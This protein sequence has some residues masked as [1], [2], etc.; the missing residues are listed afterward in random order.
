M[1]AG[2][3]PLA[4]LFALLI[5]AASAAAQ[6]TGPSDRVPRLL[7]VTATPIQSFNRDEPERVRF[8][9]LEFLGGLELEADDKRFGGISGIR[10][11][12]GDEGFLAI[13]DRAHWLRGRISVEG[14]RPVGIETLT[15]APMLD[16]NRNMLASGASFDTEA[17]A[18]GYGGEVFVGIERVNRIVRYDFGRRNFFSLARNIEVPRGI[19]NLP[20]N[21]GIEGLVF[22]P[23]N[24]PLG[25]SLIAFSERGLDKAGNIRA[26]ILGGEK[27]GEFT[28][29]R[30]D[31][32]DIT[33]A[34][35][36]PGGDIL[37]LERYFSWIR[38]IG[39]RIR[40]LR[41]A[42]IAPGK[43]VDGEVLIEAR[44]AHQIDNMEGLAVHT[45]AAGETILTI[46]SDD[47]FS[48]LQRTLLLRFRL[49]EDN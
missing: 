45:T 9:R 6:T 35:L 25:G 23:H 17:L 27:P 24:R 41:L 11:I 30:S 38:G 8:G 10:M 16:A 43:L 5:A 7:T 44:N 34:A 37:I 31:N 49:H 26:F 22:I 15:I 18:L 20:H 1:K 32:F 39:M 42:D 40:L 46:V 28:I 14:R 4:A 13:T 21:K 47:N 2:L 19:R 48:W 29:R 33:D 12:D 3:R 36:I